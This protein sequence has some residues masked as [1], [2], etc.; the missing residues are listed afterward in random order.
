MWQC[1]VCAV[2]KSCAS[3]RIV[4]ECVA[5]SMARH[6]G[7]DVSAI[8]RGVICSLSKLDQGD[9]GSNEKIKD[10]IDIAFDTPPKKLKLNKKYNI[11]HTI[12]ANIDNIVTT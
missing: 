10:I 1:H 2:S 5:D 3:L 9:D 11:K 12:T 7:V 4:Q 6:P 8:V